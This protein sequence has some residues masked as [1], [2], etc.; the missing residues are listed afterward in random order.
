[1]KQILQNL[2]NGKTE[3]V[4][5]PQP[6]LKPGFALVKNAASL[7]SAGT[8]RMWYLLQKN[9]CWRKLVHGQTW[10]SGYAKAQREGLLTTMEAAF[11]RLE[12]AYGVRLLFSWNDRWTGRRVN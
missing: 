2:R 8:E 10:W 4:E 12:S 7:V 1:M 11:N 5:V 6:Q 9:L 3:V